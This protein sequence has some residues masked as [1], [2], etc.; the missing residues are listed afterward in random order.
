MTTFPTL[1]PFPTSPYRR[2]LP[3]AFDNSM[4][5]YE[6]M[7]TVI[8]AMNNSNKLTNDMIDY[9]NKFI[10]LFDSKLY[11]TIKDILEKWREDGFFEEIITEIF[12][13]NINVV[14]FGAD[15]TG[16]KDSTQAFQTAID[17][18]SAIQKPVYVPWVKDGIYSI[19]GTL[20]AQSDLDIQVA[21]KSTIKKTKPG[22]LLVFDGES[23]EH[24]GYGRR[25]GQ[26][27]LKG[28]TW[29]GDLTQDIAISMRF[30]HTRDFKAE[31]MRIEHAVISG[32]VF[33][34]QG[35]EDLHFENIDFIGF[36]QTS[37]RYFTEAIQIDNSW[38][39]DGANTDNSILKVPTRKLTVKGCRCLPLSD[40]E[41]FPMIYPSNGL[42]D[43]VGIAYPAPNLIG[44][45][46]ER[47][48][49]AFYDINIENNTIMYGGAFEDPY[50]NQGWIHLR[51]MK[52]A[53][54]KDNK[55]YGTGSSSYALRLHMN[56]YADDSDES[57]PNPYGK[58]EWYKEGIP[59]QMENI[60]VE[61]NH[62]E[63]F[64]SGKAVM[65][66]EGYNYQGTIYPLKDV[67]VVNNMFKN[68]KTSDPILGRYIDGCNFTGNKFNDVD[69]GMQFEYIRNSNISYNTFNDMGE[70]CIDMK[71][72]NSALRGFSGGN[73]IA[74]NQFNRCTVGINNEYQ[75][76]NTIIANMF[77][78][79]IGH[80]TI[81]H[82]I[83]VF[84]SKNMMV[85]LNNA[86]T[87]N[88][89]L[90]NNF[91]ASNS[92]CKLFG[93]SHAP[94]Q[95]DTM[96]NDTQLST[97]RPVKMTMNI[98]GDSISDATHSSK[99]WHKFVSDYLREYYNF[100]LKVDAISGSGIAT[101]T[102][103]FASRV[104][105]FTDDDNSYLI[106]MGGTSDYNQSVSL[107][108]YEAK[109]R[110]LLNNC[111]NL[112]PLTQVIVSLPIYQ[113]NGTENAD[114]KPNGG[115]V[116]LK[117]YR[118]K[119]RDICGEFGVQTIEM[120]A[121]S[122]IFPINAKN[123]EQLIPDGSHPN[124]NGQKNMARVILSDLGFYK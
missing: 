106:I 33:D 113:L 65:Y 36:K 107:V 111:Y 14:D 30:F 25:G 99:Q 6:Q 103:D 69:K 115:G 58:P 90:F 123:K 79:C 17:V 77:N 2:Y 28:G 24:K 108:D 21:Y 78:Q 110:Q 114:T 10:E 37:G 112:L 46:A 52:Q 59:N 19:E 1:P 64:T 96:G 50:T 16:I 39:N 63:G 51:G 124:R 94:N 97:F 66:L 40:A 60:I 92:E 80:A 43:L 104:S 83:G 109:M 75:L 76:S 3:S 100:T 35:C 54:I 34:M 89:T 116:T 44:N 38:S 53:R 56:G 101:T 7:V 11:K 121:K 67:Y 87:S 86:V 20:K 4:D 47:R 9:L 73:I 91:S 61:G 22:M 15:P 5:L 48:G 84:N 122:G 82:L 68:I 27:R 41:Q 29:K 70:I 32:H 12:S 71:E 31:G 95:E 102:A 18:Q 8:E 55:F 118:D 57:I 105:G 62:F 74:S 88:T 117:Q 85:I 98:I 120:Q 49:F 13:K 26:I 42:P 72:P 23:V 93:N 119:M 45:H 81:G